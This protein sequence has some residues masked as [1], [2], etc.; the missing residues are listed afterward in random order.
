MNCMSALGRARRTLLGLGVAAVL[1]VTSVAGQSPADLGE[2]E[3]TS[4]LKDFLGQRAAHQYTAVRSLEASGSGQRGWLNARTDFTSAA[5]LV[6]TVTGEGGSGM[7]RS[8]VLR[9]LL[10]EEKQLIAKG[11]TGSVA[12][13]PANYALTVEGIDEQGLTIVAMRP[14]R[15]EKSLI[16]GRMFLQPDGSLVR[17]VG[18]LVK[19]PSFWVS[20]VTVSREYRRINGV[21]MPV[22]LATTAQLRLFGSASMQMTYSYSQIDE[23]PV[24]AAEAD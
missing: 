6:Y 23:Q 4:V 5:G 24:D 21:V 2:P 22:S 12:I 16:A 10:D 17:I 13:S 14:L 20:R 11:A 7:I 18:R 1:T 19:N 9:S 15:K 8:R 3:S